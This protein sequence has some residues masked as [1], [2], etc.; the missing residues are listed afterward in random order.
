MAEVL[1]TFQLKPGD[2]VPDFALPD[3]GGRIVT[4]AAAA[5]ERGLMVV[6][7]CNHCPFVIH[8]AD[9]LGDLARE[10]ALLGVNTVAINS[11]DLEKYPQ[12]GVHD[13]LRSRAPL[14]FSLSAG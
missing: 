10:I 2:R 13:G 6:F 7:V 9:A 8:L 14:G 3:A 12:D 5:G 11:N 4:R 1:S